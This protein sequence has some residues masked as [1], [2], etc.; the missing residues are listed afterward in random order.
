MEET[1]IDTAL[2][3]KL[4]SEVNGIIQWAIEGLERLMDNNYQ[5]TKSDTTQKLL[6]D[7]RKQS[8]NVIWFVEEYCELSIGLSE[9][10]SNLYQKYKRTCLENNMQPISQ[11]KFNRSLEM[12][13]GRSVIKTEDSSKRV[14]FKGIK[15]L[16]KF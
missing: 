12:E 3:M 10:S 11:T 1:K 16:K 14:L 15:T 6:D 2:V 9:Y 8:N 5:F 4:Q 7:Y 13:Y